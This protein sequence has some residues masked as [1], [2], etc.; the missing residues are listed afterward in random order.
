MSLT[1]ALRDTARRRSARPALRCSGEAIGYAA[2]IARIDARSD[3]LAAQAEPRLMRLDPID[4]IAFVT[5]FF[6]A[7]AVGR[8]LVIHA[9]GV[10][11]LL[12]EEREARLAALLSPLSDESV[13]YSSG[14]VGRGKAV[15]L[16]ESRLLLSAEAYSERAGIAPDDCVAVAVPLGQIFGF[17][18]GI[19]NPLLV[20]AE[21]LF[22]S[23]RRDPLRDA[24]A[25]GATFVLLSPA[26][27]RVAAASSGNVRLSGVLSSGG[28]LADWAA[29][30]IEEERCVRVRL[31]YGL[32]E[33]AGL[34]SR[35]YL[36]RPRRP[37]S[38][39]PPAPGLEVTIQAPDGSE[40][41]PGET[42]EILLSGGAVFRGYADPE[43]PA[44]FDEGRRLRTGD[45]GFLDME[46]ELHVRGRAVSSIRARG[47]LL[48]A[49]ELEGAVLEHAGVTEAAAISLGDAFGLLIAT[50]DSSD[51][52]L[53]EVWKH[54]ARRL[55]A[56][57]RPRR[58]RRV[59]RIPRSP[60]GKVD[61]AAAAKSFEPA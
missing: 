1:Q 24:Q 46:G 31:G 22:L 25:Q 53:E 12:R 52:L 51:E 61:R 9:E 42:G 17:V 15:P 13:F 32:T 39:G 3:A 19:V 58:L 26:Q 7:R 60:S 55:P 5:E 33:S 37:G 28:P 14:S 4:P 8:T 43:D 20:G 40:A 23:P 16:S 6:A 49:E 2:L 47:R 18:R 21:V 27:A 48:C 35:Q 38:S 29:A 50:V 57:A 44:P 41:G 36:E 56:F 34:G 59:E 11:A 30:R 45:L 10:T 54:L